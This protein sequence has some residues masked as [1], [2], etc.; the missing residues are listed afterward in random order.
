MNPMIKQRLS[1]SLAAALSTTIVSAIDFNFETTPGGF[2]IPSLSVTDSGLTLTVTAEGFPN[3]YVFVGGSSV[4]LLGSRSVIASQV[5]PLQ[6]NGFAPLRFTFSSPVSAATIFFGDAGGDTDTPVIISAYNSVGNLISTINETYGA[7]VS[8]G[9]SVN[10][11]G[12]GASYF[13]FTSLPAD[14][15][16]SL[17]WEVGNVS[18]AGGVPEVLSTVSGLMMGFGALICLR[19]FRRI[20][21]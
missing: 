20:K 21:S 8:S 15:P 11:S 12:L 7:G 6:V 5:N 1:I 10:W 9:K 16:N 4:P 18:G 13:I 17:W 14:N 19:Q 3:G 2:Y